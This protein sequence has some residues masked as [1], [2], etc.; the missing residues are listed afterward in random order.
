MRRTPDSEDSELVKRP[1]STHRTEIDMVPSSAL[2][3]SDILV[4]APQIMLSNPPPLPTSTR[5]EWQVFNTALHMFSSVMNLD[6]LDP[7]DYSAT[8]ESSIHEDL[9]TSRPA[10]ALKAELTFPNDVDDRLCSNVHIVDPSA[11]T[12]TE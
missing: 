2:S 7:T 8:W 3:W 12:V 6:L 5:Q 10:P 4:P 9:S 1:H 11:E